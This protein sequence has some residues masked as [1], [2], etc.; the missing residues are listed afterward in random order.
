MV[1]EPS[2]AVV[3]IHAA[4]TVGR[5]ADGAECNCAYAVTV[6]FAMG[7]FVRTLIALQLTVPFEPEVGAIGRFGTVTV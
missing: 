5:L 2:L 7:L 6:T 1:K 3:A 4:V